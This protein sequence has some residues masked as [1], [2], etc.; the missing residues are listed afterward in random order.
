MLSPMRRPDVS[1]DVINTGTNND[2]NGNDA[3]RCGTIN[4]TMKR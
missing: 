3:E 1:N 4:G 2:T